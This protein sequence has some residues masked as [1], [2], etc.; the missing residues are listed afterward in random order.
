MRMLMGMYMAFGPGPLGRLS[1][2]SVFLYKLVLYGA[3]VRARRA[4]NSQ[5]RRFPAQAEW[6]AIGFFGGEVGRPTSLPAIGIKIAAKGLSR[7]VLVSIVAGMITVL[8]LGTQLTS[9]SEL[10]DL[11]GSSVC[12]VKDS[13]ASKFLEDHRDIGFRVKE[14][15]TIAEMYDDF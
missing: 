9:I 3:F 2:L 15:D 5:K 10:R 1:A 6:T 14:A 4:L 7:L 8:T 11:A 13:V 12:V